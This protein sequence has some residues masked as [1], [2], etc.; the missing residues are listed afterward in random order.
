MATRLG[1]FAP[2]GVLHR[3]LGTDPAWLWQPYLACLGGLLALAL[4]ALLGRL[5]ES[6]PLRA[7][8]AALAAQPALLFGY[9][10]WGGVKELAAAAL[11]AALAASAVLIQETVST[12]AVLPLALVIPLALVTAAILAV[13]S[14]AG[15]PWLALLLP[16][17]ALVVRAHG[18]S[19][20][21]RLGAAS[22]A[23]SSSRDRAR[24]R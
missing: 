9:S 13:L 11:L 14:V 22:S 3:L 4:Y 18:W 6:G 16:A 15:A 23:C 12:R 20:A 8:A 10:L 17:A 1:P 21:A 2:L 7:L 19:S 24:G 5:V